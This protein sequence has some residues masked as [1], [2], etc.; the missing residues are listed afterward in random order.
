VSP[1]DKLPGR[2]KEIFAERDRKLQ[3]AR[4]KRAERRRLLPRGY[5]G[6]MA[7]APAPAA[8]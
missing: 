6:Q 4:E 7:S 5:Q 8:G 3:E 2:E 1:L